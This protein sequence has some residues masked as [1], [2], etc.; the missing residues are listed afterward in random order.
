[1]R[2]RNL[3]LGLL[4]L[5]LLFVLPPVGLYALTGDYPGAWRYGTERQSFRRGVTIFRVRVHRLS[6][7]KQTLLGDEWVHGEIV[8]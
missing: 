4:A 7:E 5:A 1:M 2:G 3:R 6:R 8:E